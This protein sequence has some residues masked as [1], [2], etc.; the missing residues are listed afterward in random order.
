MVQL[1]AKVQSVGVQIG[2]V[3]LGREE[4]PAENH[5]KRAVV[6]DYDCDDNVDDYDD[7]SVTLV[8]KDTKSNMD[9]VCDFKK[10][11]QK[12]SWIIFY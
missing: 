2:T 8:Y 4:G 6:E 7:L 12:T 10:T 11:W 1:M 3:W 5:R 9:F